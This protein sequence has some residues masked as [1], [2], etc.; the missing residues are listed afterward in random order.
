MYSIESVDIEIIRAWQGHFKERKW[1]FAASRSFEVQTI[2][3]NHFGKSDLTQQGRWVLN[4]ADASVLAIPGGYLNGIRALE[5]SSRLLV[6]S[7]FDLQASKADDI[8]FSIDDIPWLER[9]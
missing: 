9:G 3:I 4:A 6:F 7:D 2:S 5:E 8:R 1:L